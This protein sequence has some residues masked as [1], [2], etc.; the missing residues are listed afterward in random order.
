M[1]IPGEPKPN[2][3]LGKPNQNPLK[4][5]FYLDELTLLNVVLINKYA[6]CSF[7]VRE[8][9][10]ITMK[11][12]EYFELLNRVFEIM[13]DQDG[14]IVKITANTEFSKNTIFTKIIETED[15][16]DQEELK[17][18]IPHYVVYDLL[19]NMS[20]DLLD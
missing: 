2:D 12:W 4:V 16:E 6:Y 11:K 10:I 20:A 19:N 5:S 13:E 1:E 9:C 17:K 8:E 7:L 3:D 15:E 18:E 14:V